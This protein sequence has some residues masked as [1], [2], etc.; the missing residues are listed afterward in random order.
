MASRSGTTTARTSPTVTTVG[1]AQ[2]VQKLAMR[3]GPHRRFMALQREADLAALRHRLAGAAY[4]IGPI[5]VGDRVG[6]ARR[7]D[8]SR[9]SE[10]LPMRGSHPLSL[11][12]DRVF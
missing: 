8:R 12:E 9:L 7:I 5:E 1:H 3:A 6:D 11:G 4:R 2:P 10:S